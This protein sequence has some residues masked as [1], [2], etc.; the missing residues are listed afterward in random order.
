[1]R[2]PGM[3]FCRNPRLFLPARGVRGPT[4]HVERG[5]GIGSRVVLQRACPRLFHVERG[6]YPVW[7]RYQRALK[8]R[9]TALRQGASL[10][11]LSAWNPE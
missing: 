4:F 5:S 11:A 3:R 1:M 6:F 2:Q 7:R 8:Q 9:N 10:R